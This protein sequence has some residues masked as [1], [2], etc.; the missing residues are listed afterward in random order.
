MRTSGLELV[1][2]LARVVPVTKTGTA[3]EDWAFHKYPQNNNKLC[4]IINKLN[5]NVQGGQFQVILAFN[6]LTF[7]NTLYF[8]CFYIHQTK[9]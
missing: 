4:K 6:E 9:F 7:G 1:Q 2:V 8:F 5:K 3:L